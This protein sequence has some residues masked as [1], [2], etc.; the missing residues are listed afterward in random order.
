MTKPKHFHKVKALE[1]ALANVSAGC[2]VL[3][4]RPLRSW[5]AIPHPQEARLAAFRAIPSRYA[6]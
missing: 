3:Q 5:P 6:K 2:E 1:S 4:S